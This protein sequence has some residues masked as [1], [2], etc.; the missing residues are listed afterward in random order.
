MVRFNHV[1]ITLRYDIWPNFAYG[2]FGI[3]RVGMARGAMHGFDGFGLAGGLKLVELRGPPAPWCGSQR[4]DA[5]DFRL[6][7]GIMDTSWKS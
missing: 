3:E 4:V 2:S 1:L 7:A 6:L 5:A